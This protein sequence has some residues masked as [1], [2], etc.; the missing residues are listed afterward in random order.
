MW[1]FLERVDRVAQEAAAAAPAV[2]APGEA[3][4]SD[5]VDERC[6]QAVLHEAAALVTPS[7]GK[8][9]GWRDGGRVCAVEGC[10]RCK[11]GAAV[12]YDILAPRLPTAAARAP[13]G[14]TARTAQPART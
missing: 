13:S 1:P 12:P 9:C 2:A 14:L 4:V 10:R 7:V 8:V 6:W 5:D 11:L 3:G